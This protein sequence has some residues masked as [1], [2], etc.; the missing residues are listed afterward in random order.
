MSLLLRVE[1]LA[2]IAANTI[3]LQLLKNMKNNA[4]RNSIRPSRLISWR[5]NGNLIIFS[6]YASGVLKKYRKRNN[7]TIRFPAKQRIA[8]IVFWCSSS[9]LLRNSRQCGRLTKSL[10]LKT[11]TGE[12][13]CFA[14][15]E[16]MAILKKI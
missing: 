6:S 4:K 3:S 14:W 7:T 11:F 1:S 15:L 9:L 16:S 2:P 5:L 8:Y 13:N 10:P 12:E